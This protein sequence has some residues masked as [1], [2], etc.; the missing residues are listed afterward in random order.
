MNRVIGLR[1]SRIQRVSIKL[2]NASQKAMMT[3]RMNA[4]F[5]IISMPQKSILFVFAKRANYCIMYHP[6]APTTATVKA[7]ENYKSTCKVIL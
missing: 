6:K 1:K 7:K 2:T 5:A 3:A 4:T